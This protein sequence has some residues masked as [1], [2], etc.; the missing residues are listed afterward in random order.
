MSAY[1]ESKKAG[2]VGEIE[3][4]KRILKKHPLAFIDNKGKANSDWDIWIPEKNYGVEVKNDYKSYYTGNLVLEVEM[5][6]K[7][8]ALSLTKAKYWV[9]ITGERYIWITPLD[10]YRFIEQ[11]FEYGR[12]PFTGDGDEKEKLAYLVRHDVFVKYVHGLGK[13]R[14]W[15]EMIKKND[16]MYI[17]NFRN[18]DIEKYLDEEKKKL[19]I[20]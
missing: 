10:T 20:K 14:G 12:V 19:G 2:D 11:H 17:D 1:Y 15:V 6:G 13:E 7:L 4:L 8:S 18:L 9:F 3:V 16:V 5:D